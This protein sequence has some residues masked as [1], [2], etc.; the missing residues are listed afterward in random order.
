MTQMETLWCSRT[1]Y[2][3]TRYSRLEFIIDWDLIRFSFLLTDKEE[4]LKCKRL[5]LFKINLNKWGHQCFNNSKWG[6]LLPSSNQNILNEVVSSNMNSS[7]REE[8]TGA[9][10]TMEKTSINHPD[11]IEATDSLHLT[12]KWAAT[13]AVISSRN[14][15]ITRIPHSKTRSN[16]LRGSRVLRDSS[17]S[18]NSEATPKWW[19]ISNNSSSFT[20]TRGEWAPRASIRGPLRTLVANIK[21]RISK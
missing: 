11:F 9:G 14:S 21:P 8:A 2:P 12:R 1:P 19:D 17:S 16:I 4:L 20:Q 13:I 10:V 18:S 3:M 7:P 15:S 6:H 5:L